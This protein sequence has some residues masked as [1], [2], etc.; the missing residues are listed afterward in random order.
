MRRQRCDESGQRQIGGW[1]RVDPA[2]PAI[3]LGG[4]KARGIVVAFSDQLPAEKLVAPRIGGV[5]TLFED[6]EVGF[7]N[8]HWTPR[9]GTILL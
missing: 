1:F 5:L 6:L 2:Q 9:C 4:E 8:L 7:R 3:G